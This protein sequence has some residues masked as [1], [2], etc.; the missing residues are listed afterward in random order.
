MV[1]ALQFW[2]HY[3]LPKEFVLFS[4]HEA[5]KDLNCQHK[6]SSR[7]AKWLTSLQEFTLTLH[8]KSSIYNNVSEG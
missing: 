6:L 8:H 4:D 5:L 3:L 2:C 7:N 1:Q